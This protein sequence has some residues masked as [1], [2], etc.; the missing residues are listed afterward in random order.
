MPKA[1]VLLADNDPQAW[2]WS[3]LLSRRD[4]TVTTA[5]SLESAKN[6]LRGSDFDV[7]ILDLRLEDDLDKNDESGRKLAEEYADSLPIIILSG[8]PS[9][10]TLLWVMQHRDPDGPYLSVVDK[11]QG[12]D[13]LL[14]EMRKALPPKV[15][16]SHGHDDTATAAVQIF[17][18]QS[19]LQPVILKDQPGRSEPVLD[20][21]ERHAEVEFAVVLVTPDDMGSLKGE[22]PKPRARQNVVFE[23]GYF[24][25][26]L[27]RTRVVALCKDDADGIEWPSNYKG[28]LYQTMDRDDG[29]KYKL[30]KA[31]KSAGVDIHMV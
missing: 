5:P 7:A 6:A 3:D 10:K 2:V 24:L 14:K 21:L 31:M 17:L 18:R 15:F 4:Y 25:G 12:I 19:G 26:K 8:E 27:G 23:L 30:G 16:V 22:P 13:A 28:V 29:W 11:G 20:L 1:R 9:K